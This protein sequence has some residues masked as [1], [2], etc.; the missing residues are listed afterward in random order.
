MND[1]S[2]FGLRVNIKASV[3]F[4]QGINV[5]QF[6]DDADPFDTPEIAISESAMGLNGD[7]VNWSV[8]TPITVS[9]AVVP[10]SDDDRNLATLFEANRV[11]RGK[12]SARDEITLAAVYPDGRSITM[13]KGRPT[14]LTPSNSVASGGRMK[15]KTYGFVF[16][17]KVGA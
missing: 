7:L 10:N 15:S 16:E 6:A 9:I 13:T 14:M 5:T 1:I 8:A 3:T 4:P 2:G 11:G 17:N 12:I